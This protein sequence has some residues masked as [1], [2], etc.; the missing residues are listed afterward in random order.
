MLTQLADDVSYCVAALRLRAAKAQADLEREQAQAASSKPP[1]TSNAPIATWSNS[2]TSPRTTSRSRCGPSAVTSSS[3]STASR[4]SWMPRPGSYIAGAFDGATRMERLI[5]D[6]LAFSR[7]GTRGGDFLPADLD[8]VLQQAL[9]NLQAGI[10]SAQAT[11]T[12]DPLPTLPVDA[13]QI[14]QLFQNLIGNA[15][16]FQRRGAPENPCRRAK[17]GRALGLLGA[18]QRHRH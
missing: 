16:K 13:T 6:L 2:P 15:L 4:T 1:K 11:V 10:E 17:A 5:T 3:S 12:H 7:V 14:M 8:A 18:R 9:R